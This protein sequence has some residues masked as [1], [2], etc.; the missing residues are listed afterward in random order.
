MVVSMCRTKPDYRVL[1]EVLLPE[2]L[3]FYDDPENERAFQEWK[4]EREKKIS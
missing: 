1:A 2:V 3:A 4:Q